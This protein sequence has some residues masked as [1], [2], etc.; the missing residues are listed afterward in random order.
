MRDVEIAARFFALRHAEHYQRGMAG[1]LD[2]YYVRAR[3]FTEQD[4]ETL[5]AVLETHDSVR[6][7]VFASTALALSPPQSNPSVS[8]T[9][10]EVAANQP[11]REVAATQPAAPEVAAN[12]SAAN[13]V[14]EPAE[15]V[16]L[17]KTAPGKSAWQVYDHCAAF[18]RLY[19]VFEQFIEELVGEY[20]RMLPN[21][22]LKYEDLPENVKT[23]H[24]IGIGQILL[25]LGKEGLYS[26]LDEKQII[27]H[28]AEA[29]IG[30]PNYSLLP[31]AF[32]LDPHNYRADVLRRL[33][34][35]LGFED[36][37]AWVEAHPLVLAY[38]DT[39]DKTETPATILHDLVEYRNK[40]AHTSVTE[41]V[42]TDEIK[43]IADCVVVICEALAQVVMK[44]VVRRR[45]ELG[46]VVHVGDVIHKYSDHIV[47]VRTSAGKITVGDEI[48]VVRKHACYKVGVI[49]IRTGGVSHQQLDV[50][51]NQ[52]I[53]MKLTLDAGTG[54]ELMRFPVRA[55]TP[56]AQPIEVLSPDEYPLEPAEPKDDYG[57][58]ETQ[59]GAE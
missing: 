43:S 50:V 24:R 30:S 17:R 40:A 23:Q 1:F 12:Q 26:H 49:S 52:E 48:I 15:L 18:T 57:Q 14:T 51:E 58:E 35:Q 39:R 46:E 34:Q 22:Y 16:D 21:M 33:F 19:A 13:V 41:T 27:Q 29:L 8:P 38:M 54:A 59:A 10:P 5:K 4:L 44:Q 45:E 3:R 2:I 53:G 55:P 7:L 47:G 9:S 31:D 20:L 11:A 36:C 32:F 37:W 56:A 6:Q 28:L 42:A 25:K